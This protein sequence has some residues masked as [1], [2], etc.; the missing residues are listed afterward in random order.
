[1]KLYAV[2]DKKAKQIVATFTSVN[3]EFAK[4]SFE[5][6]LTAPE[7]D[8]YNLFPSQFALMNVAEL[9]FD[10]YLSV[11]KVGNEV[12]EASGFKGDSYSVTDFVIDGDEFTASY[13]QK[14][15]E[16]RY[17]M[18]LFQEKC[19]T[20]SAAEIREEIKRINRET[21]SEQNLNKETENNV[22][23]NSK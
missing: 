19:S 4:R 12:L 5:M 23:C 18:L 1:M 10:G 20:R 3:D 6:L 14:Q 21:F 9:N 17:A 13:I 2:V 8:I 22:S 11:R 7:D 15:R 16:K